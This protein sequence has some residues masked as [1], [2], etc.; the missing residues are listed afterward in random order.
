MPKSHT[1][2]HFTRQQLVR[3]AGIERSQG[4]SLSLELSLLIL[5]EHHYPHLSY[6]FQCGC[7]YLFFLFPT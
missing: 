3:C 2:T 7:L 6:T 5:W 4:L 1:Y